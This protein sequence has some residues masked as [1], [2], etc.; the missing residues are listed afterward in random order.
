[1]NDFLEVIILGRPYI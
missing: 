1:M